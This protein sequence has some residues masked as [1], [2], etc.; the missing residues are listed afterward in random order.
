MLQVYISYIAAKHNKNNVWMSYTHK[1]H[2]HPQ[3]F[4]LLL[5][6][7]MLF[8]S[9]DTLILIEGKDNEKLSNM[10]IFSFPK[11]KNQRKNC[12]K[13]HFCNINIAIYTLK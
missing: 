5:M 10:Q 3:V 1:S 11:G 13:D 2:G 7:L 8:V 4:G 12:V 6:N 9:Y